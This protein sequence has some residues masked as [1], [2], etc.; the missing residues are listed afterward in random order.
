MMTVLQIV[1]LLLGFCAY[2]MLKIPAVLK[3][4][5]KTNTFREFCSTNVKEFAISVL[6]LI[7]LILAGPE[8]PEYINL[9]KP[10]SILI[11]GGSIPSMFYNLIGAFGKKK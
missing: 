8:Y 11:A 4:D 10:V 7:F 6:G 3:S 2:W 5:S 1:Y 9:S